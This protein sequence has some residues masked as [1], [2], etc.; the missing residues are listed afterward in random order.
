L[1]IVEKRANSQY[2]GLT[3]LS[4]GK[5]IEVVG[6]LIQVHPYAVHRLHEQQGVSTLYR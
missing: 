4:T 5:A 3:F 1:A 2:N 6:K